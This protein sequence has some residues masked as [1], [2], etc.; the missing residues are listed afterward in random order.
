MMSPEFRR[1]ALLEASRLARENGKI[2]QASCL[3][4]D[5]RLVCYLWDLPVPEGGMS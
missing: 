5:A 2:I 4:R 1:D 3:A